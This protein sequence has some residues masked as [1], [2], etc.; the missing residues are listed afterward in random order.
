MRIK[1]GR[2]NDAGSAMESPFNTL[3]GSILLG[4]TDVGAHAISNLD[5]YLR[6]GT[7]QHFRD[8]T[9]LHF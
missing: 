9:I 5:L 4:M 8:G 3:L 2:R 7:N 6:Q 1:G